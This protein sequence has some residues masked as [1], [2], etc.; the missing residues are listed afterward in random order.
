MPEPSPTRPNDPER[1]LEARIE[2]LIAQ[3]TLDEK[4]SLIHG[5]SMFTGAGVPR[6]GIPPRSISD[7]P[8]GV[9]E[10]VGPHSWEPAGRTDDF[11]TYLPVGIC[12]A[13]TWNPEL[14]R[15]YGAVIG[16]EA[17]QRG[18]DMM[19]G[20]GVNMMRTPLCGRNFEYMGEDPHLTSRMA[21]GYI[22]GLQSQGVAACVKHFAVNNQEVDR[23]TISVEADD[24]TLREIYWPAFEAAVK[25]AG[26]WTVMGAY[27]RL[28]GQ[29][30]CHH[31]LLLNR[32]LKGEWGFQGL[33][34]SDW[35]GTHDTGEAARNG[36]D[37]E[38]G[39]DRDYADYHMSQPLKGLV[40]SGD[41]PVDLIDE[42]V[43]RNLR[44]MLRTVMRP[45]RAAGS[46]NTASHQEVALR[47]AE[48][49]IV[50]L[51]ND[52]G[53]LPLDASL[54]A[55]AV[56]GENAVRK[57]AYGGGSSSIKAFYEVTPLEGVIRRTGGVSTV[58]WAPG[59][60]SRQAG[61]L[62]ERAVAAAK[63]SEVA[64]I[65]AGLNH[66]PH[67][68]HEGTDRLDLQ[69]PYGQDELIL[70]VAEANP[71]TVVVLVSGGPV[72]M[73]RWIDQVTAVV[74]AW[75]PGMEGG[76]AIA[77]VLFGDANPSGKL[78]CTFPKRL[79]DSPAHANGT[80]PGQDGS[81]AYTEGLL[82]GYRW[83][84]TKG[85]EPLFPFGHGLSYASFAYSGLEI[86]PNAESDCVATVRFAVEN[87]G[88]VS[89]AEVAQVYVR[90]PQ[91][92]LPR[93][94]QEL[95]G[96]AKVHLEPGERRMVS[97]ELGPRAFS[98]FDPGRLAWVAESGEY[99]IRVGG[100]SR[101]IALRSSFRLQQDLVVAV[102]EPSASHQGANP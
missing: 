67:Q 69:L 18:K 9:R 59:Y 17:L 29:H 73:S 33:V 22:E 2:S 74:Q 78:P 50:L 62:L 52:G 35:A 82:I 94:E 43:R 77:R 65:V 63:Q 27:N 79:S 96:F 90:D 10:D 60:S 28:R 11:S 34:V 23:H 53:L 97:I 95:K 5:D 68:D 36:L 47:V 57:H 39:T 102:S 71:R 86:V 38:M 83:F 41:V 31:D 4:I 91:S 12:L 32:I 58:I 55:I 8:H 19:L 16:E 70:R 100:S 66:D 13:A 37:L 87:K 81:V 46:L 44:V 101:G 26:V 99:E 15:S 20:P 3:M 30:C 98:F 14:A 92:S 56:I 64:V 84:D 80:Y 1:E 88:V 93:P 7:G 51:K 24:R 48:E 45:Q 75:Y 40:E 49:G 21:V 89:G 61:G 72:E 85:I 25:E 6:L 76:N 42:K 54:S